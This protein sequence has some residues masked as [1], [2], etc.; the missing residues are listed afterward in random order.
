[1]DLET[2]IM[3]KKQLATNYE[4]QSL[5]NKMKLKKNINK[6]NKKNTIHRTE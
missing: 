3:I 2:E 5:I 6:K 1:M 4:V